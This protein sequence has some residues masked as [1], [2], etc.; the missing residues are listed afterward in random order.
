LLIRKIDTIDYDN[1]V[2][3]IICKMSSSATTKT[4][5]TQAK[6]KT[7]TN[8]SKTEVKKE[9]LPRYVSVELSGEA[10]LGLHQ[11]IIELAKSLEID[12]GTYEVKRGLADH[13]HLT[14][15]FSTDLELDAYREVIKEYEAY[16]DQSLEIIVTGVAID[17]TC[18]TLSAHPKKLKSYPEGRHSHITMMLHNQASVYSN[19][20]LTRTFSQLKDKLEKGKFY[21]IN[22]EETGRISHYH[23]L[24]EPVT[25]SGLLKFI[26]YLKIKAPAITN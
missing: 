6:P 2:Q 9:S 11:P 16:R 18:I 13:G 3:L 24:S 26:G 5:S 21:T 19:T 20:L 1:H 23:H 15:V 25:V 14:M 8:T 7:S 4:K 12:L 22:D 17:S 10:S